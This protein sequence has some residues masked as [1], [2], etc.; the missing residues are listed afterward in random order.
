MR[1]QACCHPAVVRGSC[2][3]LGKKDSSMEGL[4]ERL[5]SNIKVECEDAHRKLICALNGIAGTILNGCKI[6]SLWGD[7]WT[8]IEDIFQTYICTNKLSVPTMKNR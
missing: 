1:T 4:L 3:S 5:I 8:E 7:C 6:S 2:L